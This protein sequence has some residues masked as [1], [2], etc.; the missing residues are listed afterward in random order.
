MLEE[1]VFSCGTPSIYVV[2]AGFAG[3]EPMPRKRGLL[4]LRAVKSRNTYGRVN[5]RVP[6]GRQ[7]PFQ[8]DSSGT[9]VTLTGNCWDRRFLLTVTVTAAASLGDGGPL[10]HSRAQR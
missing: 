9:I 2:T 3:L 6:E 10:G 1:L 5:R 7:P 4:S 8:S